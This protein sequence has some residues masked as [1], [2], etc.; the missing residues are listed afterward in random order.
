MKDVY[1]KYKLKNMVD[2]LHFYIVDTSDMKVA[3]LILLE[4]L[5]NWLFTINFYKFYIQTWFPERLVRSFIGS[6]LGGVPAKQARDLKFK[7]QYCKQVN[8]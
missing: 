3:D 5:G 2:H 7:H 6:E 8:K 1:K 4:V